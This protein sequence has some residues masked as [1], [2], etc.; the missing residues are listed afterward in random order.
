MQYCWK[1][2]LTHLIQKK[3]LLYKE[4]NIQKKLMF[5][6]WKQK[7]KDSYLFREKNFE[8]IYK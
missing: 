6:Y 5:F 8:K 3:C 1:K 2:M 7:F 4:I